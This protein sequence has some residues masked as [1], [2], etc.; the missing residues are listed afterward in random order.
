MLPGGFFFGC[1]FVFFLDEMAKNAHFLLVLVNEPRSSIKGA[2]GN[3]YLGKWDQ[4]HTAHGRY[5]RK[6][7]GWTSGFFGESWSFYKTELS[8]HQRYHMVDMNQGQVINV[9]W[10]VFFKKKHHSYNKSGSFGKEEVLAI[11]GESCLSCRRMVL[12][13]G[14]WSRR[15]GLNENSDL[16]RPFLWKTRS[17][18]CF[19]WCLN[20]RDVA[21]DIEA[22]PFALKCRF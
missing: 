18:F 5:F 13:I 10:T 6:S 1:F 7:I 16:S 14:A 21:Y 8:D 22:V 12:V 11:V 3:L 20:S 9:V 19:P 17:S 2:D 15:M 4:K